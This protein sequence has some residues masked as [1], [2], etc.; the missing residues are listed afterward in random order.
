[1]KTFILLILTVFSFTTLYSQSTIKG[2]AKDKS[3]NT[4]LNG[5][6][7]SI[8]NTNKGTFT[9]DNGEFSISNVKAGT[10]NLVITYLG[11]KKREVSNVTV[12]DGQ[13]LNLTIDLEEMESRLTEDVIVYGASKRA[14]LAKNTP[15][16]VTALSQVEIQKAARSNQVGNALEGQ[17]GVD[18][19]RNGNADFQ[20]NTRG[21]NNSTNRRLLILVDGRDVALQQIGAPEWNSLTFPMEDFQNIELIRGPSA[22]LFG[23]NAFNGVLNL[24]TYAPKDVVGTKVSLLGGDYNTYRADVRHAG[25][26]DN[27]SYRVNV[28][29]MG[30]RNLNKDRKATSTDPAQRALDSAR[31]VNDG[32]KWLWPNGIEQ[33]GIADDERNSFSYYGSARLDYQLNSTSHIESEFGYTQFGNEFM[34]AG[35]GRIH[36]PE[37]SKKFGRL[38]Y[39][40]EK[41]Q[42]HATYNDRN[43]LDTMRILAAPPGTIILDHAFDV[44]LDLQYNET[45]ADNLFLT[46]GVQGQYMF[47]DSRG[48]VFRPDSIHAN[49]AGAYAQLDFKPSDQLR[50][51]GSARV[52]RASIHPTQFSPRVSVVYTPNSEHTF[53][54]TGGRAFQRPNFSELYR[55]YNF[56]PALGAMGPINFRPV[57][58]AINQFLTNQTGQTQNVDLGLFSGN[59]PQGSLLGIQPQSLGLGNTSL[60]VESNNSYELGYRGIITNNLSVN[61]EGYYSR[62]QNFISGFLPGANEQYK[63][64]SSASK[65]SP[66]LAQYAAQID[67]IVYSALPTNFD[68]SRLSTVDGNPAFVISNA[69]IGLIENFGIDA[70]VSYFPMRN[71]EL[72]ANYSYFGFNLLDAK[73]TNP[74]LQSG[75]ELISPNTSPHRVN[76]SATYQEPG[77]FDITVQFRYV[78][79][80]V[81]LAGDFRGEVPAYALVNLNGGYQISN[82]LKAGFNIYNLLDRKHYQIL[83]G[84][85]IPR[86]ANA[87]LSYTF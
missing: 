42:A 37:T 83:G 23:P 76:L 74:F 33:N 70:G 71:L 64:W 44:N 24:R 53:R 25:I 22:A 39:V 51:I 17:L 66:E 59:A 67:S 54:L 14:E 65:L 85:L 81:W 80:F 3:T 87:S 77:L 15:A 38:K 29:T 79:S 58:G 82:Q 7:V 8:S 43:T 52:D 21:F 16:A 63:S 78:D 35:A 34:M 1:M 27:F 60:T 41:F 28:G 45:L 55:R 36:V 5:V 13:N 86:L 12:T 31:I 72:Q 57:Q 73:T 30:S 9:K 6:R 56:R 47:M 40:S 61:I 75:F 18:V 84:T 69:N 46:A 68:K 4:P 49:F 10:Y 26:I 50:I 2:I 11:Y 62:L 48:T 20:V 19:T 32:Y